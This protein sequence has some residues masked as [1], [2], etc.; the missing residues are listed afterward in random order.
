M[1]FNS[2][3]GLLD[4]SLSCVLCENKIHNFKWKAVPLDKAKIFLPLDVL[5]EKLVWSLS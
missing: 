1:E 5:C 2:R 3:R 4:K